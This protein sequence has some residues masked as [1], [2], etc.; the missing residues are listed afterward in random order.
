MDHESRL[1]LWRADGKGTR[2]LAKGPGYYSETVWSP[3]GRYVAVR[4]AYPGWKRVT[5]AIVDMVAGTETEVNPT[6]LDSG[7]LSGLRL[8]ESGLLGV[9]LPGS[10]SEG[11][12]DGAM[13]RV[14]QG[15]ATEATDAA[16]M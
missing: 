3:N 5:A 1:R 6:H 7:Q 10:R 15:A 11:R 16:G 9:L 14:M 12:T 8:L 4:K 13:E 2:T